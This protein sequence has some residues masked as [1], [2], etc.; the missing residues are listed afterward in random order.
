MWNTMASSYY[1][2]VRFTQNKGVTFLFYLGYGL[3]LI[4]LK[5]PKACLQEKSSQKNILLT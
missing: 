3:T 4:P 1:S 2:K 5:L